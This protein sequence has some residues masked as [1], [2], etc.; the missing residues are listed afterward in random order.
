MHKIVIVGGGFAG[1][2][3]ALDLA[4]NDNIKVTLVDRNNYNF[5]PPLLYQVATGMLDVASISTSFRTLFKGKKNLKFRMG[6]LLSVHQEAKQIELDNGTVEYDYL[7]IA[8]GATSNYFGNK[9]IERDSLPMKT[10]DESI[11][12]RNTLLNV[13]EL[14]SISDEEE[15]EKRER[16]IVIAGGGPAGVEVAGMLAELRNKALKKIYPE[17]NSDLLK[18]YL[19]EG[20][21]SLLG[22][23]S[24]ESCEYAKKSLEDLGV[25]IVLNTFVE[26]FKD[27]EVFLKGKESLPTRTLIWTAGVTAFRFEGLPDASYQRGNRLEVDEFNKLKDNDSIFAIGDACIQKHDK[28]Y[29]NGFP[30]LGSVAT[31]QGK[32]LAKNIKRL[33]NN[34]P[35]KPFSYIDKGTMAIIGKSKATADMRFPKKTIT[36][37]FAWVTW[38]SVH[39][40]LLI[41]YRNKIK[42]IWQWTTSYFTTTEPDGLIIG[43]SKFN[44]RKI[45]QL[46]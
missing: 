21:S 12:L 14:F 36:G 42:T 25:I 11:R 10:I 9:S 29:E 46:K 41:N 43:K 6:K 8:T 30:Q 20:G 19:I 22:G 39:L 7:V 23:M 1:V 37:W 24:K 32:Q 16:N 40:F 5:F 17:I 26:D 15:G 34:K 4:N 38:L 33:L 27:D 44:V 45:D 28:R 3:L 18:I 2:N 35:L 31:Q 13:A